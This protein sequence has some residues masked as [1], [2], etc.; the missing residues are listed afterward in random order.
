MRLT[1]PVGVQHVGGERVEQCSREASKGSSWQTKS[2]RKAKSLH[3]DV[4][5]FTKDLD[6]R[7]GTPSAKRPAVLAKAEEAEAL[8][9]ELTV[10]EAGSGR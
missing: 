10:A 9:K 2:C 1:D 3:A 5:R 7:R 6:A 8:S 4:V